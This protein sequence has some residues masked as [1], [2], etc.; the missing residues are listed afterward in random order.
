MTCTKVTWLANWSCDT[1][2]EI[3]FFKYYE[4]RHIMELLKPNWLC[5][6]GFVQ[7]IC[8]WQISI[9]MIVVHISILLR[10]DQWLVLWLN[11]LMLSHPGCRLRMWLRVINIVGVCLTGV[12]STKRTR[13]IYHLQ[14]PGR[15]CHRT[16]RSEYSQLCHVSCVARVPQLC[17]ISSAVCCYLSCVMSPQ[18]CAVTSAVC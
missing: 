18:L 10:H 2:Y 15:Q 5:L 13:G 8:L 14:N 11:S 6:F 17:A 4:I 12:N 7:A 1:Y 9:W 3:V 16:A